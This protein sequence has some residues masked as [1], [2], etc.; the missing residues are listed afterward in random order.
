MPNFTTAKCLTAACAL[1]LIPLGAVATMT[2]ATPTTAKSLS[3][4]QLCEI[5]A[6]SDDGLV[7]LD[8]LVHADS[9]LSGSYSFRV[10]KSGG[11]GSSTI[12]QGGQFDARA[13]E[14]ATLGSVSLG[15]GG[16]RYKATL[17]VR[18]GAKTVTCAKQVGSI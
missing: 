6:T 5:D 17:D 3:P 12:N 8:A 10:E 18:I 2:T 7:K 14:T 16:A 13:G 11:G 4:A 15:S 9:A 1:V